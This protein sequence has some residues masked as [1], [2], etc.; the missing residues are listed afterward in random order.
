MTEY[1][2]EA[3]CYRKLV[4]SAK[5]GEE[6]LVQVTERLCVDLPAGVLVADCEGTVISCSVLGRF[7]PFGK[8]RGE[9]LDTVLTGQL[10]SLDG[11]LIGV[12]MEQLAIRTASKKQLQGYTAY[13]YSLCA[14]GIRTGSLLV[15]L[16]GSLDDKGIGLCILAS[17]IASLIMGHMENRNRLDRQRKLEAVKS[18]TETLSYSELMACACIF[19]ELD[20]KEGLIVASR[21][22]DKESITRSVIV[23]A[24]R[25]LEGAGIIESR[26]LGMK[27]TY[28]KVLNG[29][30]E[31]EIKKINKSV[32]KLSEN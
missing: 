15:Y 2:L 8:K 1:N 25:K 30:F 22:A 27:G 14:F 4:F 5:S 6:A 31:S 21:I 11:D 26:S 12:P 10:G 20:G 19:N 13:V 7:N 24:I 9:K 23:N 17:G 18:V 29:F 3:D 28:I 32:E 16:R